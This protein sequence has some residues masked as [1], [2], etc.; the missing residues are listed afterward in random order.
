MALKKPASFGASSQTMPRMQLSRSGMHVEAK[1]TGHM[2]VGVLAEVTIF[3]NIEL[4]ESTQ[5]CR[6]L[7]R[8]ISFPGIGRSKQTVVMRALIGIIERAHHN[9]LF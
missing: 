7:S 6:F 4:S 1:V 2:N 5:W 3:M 9:S 8:A